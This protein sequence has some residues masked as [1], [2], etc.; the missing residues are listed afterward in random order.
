MDTFFVFRTPFF[1]EFFWEK[2]SSDLRS[3]PFYLFFKKIPPKRD[4]KNKK[5]VHKKKIRKKWKKYFFKKQNKVIG[6]G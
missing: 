3:K 4:P 5:S 2:T 1:E 6:Y